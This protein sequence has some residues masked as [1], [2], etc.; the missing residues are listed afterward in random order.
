MPLTTLLRAAAWIAVAAIAF[1]W[2]RA[3]ERFFA[4][5]E[6]LASGIAEEKPL[7]VA[8]SAA[9]LVV[10]VRIALLPWWPI[11]KPVIHDEFGYLLLA[12]TFSLGR[13]T[14]PAHPLAAF[15]ESPFILQH[16][17]YTA[18]F[19]PGTGLVMAA[20]QIVFGYPWFG[21]V[22]SCAGL[23]AVL[24]WALRGWLPA[25]WTL[26]GAALAVNMVLFSY[27]MDSYW[28]GSLTAV[29]G[30]LVTG[31]LGRLLHRPF[32]MSFAAAFALG[33][34]ILVYNRPYEGLLVLAPS[35]VI[36]A[37]RRVAIRFW[38]VLLLI[39]LPAAGWLGYY[40]KRVTGNVL[41]LPYSEYDAQYAAP[42][43]FNILPLQPPIS[44]P[45]KN[46]RIMDQ[47][48]RERYATATSWKFPRTRLNDYQTIL[49]LLAGSLM[50]AVPALLFFPFVKASRRLRP[51]LWILLVF[52]A[53]SLI[54][55][56]LFEHYAA[57]AVA[58]LLVVLVQGFRH[59]RLWR[60]HGR[61]VGRFLSRA[62]P[63][64]ML[65]IVLAREGVRLWKQVPVENTK[66]V[67]YRRDKLEGLLLEQGPAHL[68]VVRYTRN[69]VPHE[70]WIYN[71]ADID[72]S[73]VVWAQDLG[74][75]E[76]R[77]LLSYYHYRTVWLLQPDDDPD[78]L[79]P[80]PQ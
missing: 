65:A 80:Y 44:F 41:R 48:E 61:P 60:Y 17:T 26:L 10:I 71:H 67:N 1:A 52:V 22:A 36:L 6:S 40:H 42:P 8:L 46:M 29:G 5:L 32:R 43:H 47:W 77:R 79:E 12:D 3:G 74:A 66:A 76:N 16:P 64:V 53:G 56:L 45:Q 14:N 50:A 11:P 2:P 62:I 34:V 38:A 68:I 75:E 18:K 37:W 63:A 15:F 59:L 30:G 78:R 58:A 51:L 49:T 69:Q 19:F 20:F 25:R 21:V 70:E 24:I 57:P 73:P 13:L 72:N 27:W 7:L 28:G 4:R 23:M 39:S 54:E 35:I 55:T 33:S 9:A 31:A